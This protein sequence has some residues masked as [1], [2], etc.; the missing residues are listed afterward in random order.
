[1]S[2]YS[3]LFHIKYP[4]TARLAVLKVWV[5]VTL[6]RTVLMNVTIRTHTHADIRN[7]LRVLPRISRTKLIITK[8]V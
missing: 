1:M 3:V 8:V 6:N 7:L 2:L 4:K 5:L